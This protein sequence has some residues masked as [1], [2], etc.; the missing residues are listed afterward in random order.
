MAKKQ[1]AAP[2]VEAPPVLPGTYTA[3]AVLSDLPR[4]V[5]EYRRLQLLIAEVAPYEAQKKAIGAEIQ[6]LLLAAGEK[7]VT[8]G[9]LRATFVESAGRKTLSQDRLLANGVSPDVIAASYEIGKPS[10]SVR[11]TKIDEE[12]EAATNGYARH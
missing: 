11:V 10:S 9:D 3:H 5:A 6:A 8:V 2:A 7:S 1:T 12:K 4:F